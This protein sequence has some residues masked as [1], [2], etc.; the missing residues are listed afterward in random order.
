MMFAR[1][2]RLLLRPGWVEDAPALTAAFAREDVVLKLATA[3]WPYTVSD[4]ETYLGRNR[5]VGEADMLIFQRTMGAPRLIGGIGLADR[6]GDLELGYWIVPSH[7]GLGFATEAGHAVIAMA[8]DTLRLDRIV[9]GH[10]TDNPAS[11]RVLGKLGFTQTGSEMRKSSARGLD[12]QCVTMALDL[13]PMAM[14]A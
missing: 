8:R 5:T 7:W 12:M 1:T 13:H 14:A 4:A 11:G 10:F 6:D 3:P 9:S 2:E